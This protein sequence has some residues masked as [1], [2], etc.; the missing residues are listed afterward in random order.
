[1]SFYS[2]TKLH[3]LKVLGTIVAVWL[4]PDHLKKSFYSATD[5][6]IKIIGRIYID[7]RSEEWFSENADLFITEGGQRNINGNYNLPQLGIEV[8]QKQMVRSINEEAQRSDSA[9]IQ[10]SPIQLKF[11]QYILQEFKDS[12]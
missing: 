5:D 3:K 8:R 2:Q 11:I 1:M 10:L 7:I 4:V 6:T 9:E 12:F